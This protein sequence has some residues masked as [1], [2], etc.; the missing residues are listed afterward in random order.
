[1]RIFWLAGLAGTGKTSIAVTLCRM[2]QNDGQ[3]VFGGAFFCSRTANAAELTDAR[4]IIPTLATALA[5]RFPSFASALA[6]ELDSDAHAALKPINAQ[7][8]TLLR[9]PL[10]GISSVTS[11]IVFVVDALDECRDEN[12]VK[13]VLRA[14]SSLNCDTVVKFIFTS[15]PETHISTS[16]ISSSDRNSII[17]LHMIDKE[18]VTEDIHRY[19]ADAFTKSPLTKPWYSEADMRTLSVLSD[20]LFIFAS[21]MIVYILKA[22]SVK[23]R[24]TRLRTAL[25][26]VQNSKVVRGPLD[27]MYDLVLTRASDTAEIEPKELE[28]TLK[29]L[30]SIL[31]ARVPL[32]VG[33]LAD[34][35]GLEV[36]ELQESLQ[37]VHALV[38]VPE[39][40]DQPGLRT[41]HASFGDYLLAQNHISTSLGNETL[42]GGTLRF[43]SQRLHFNVSES[44]SSYAPNSAF[45]HGNITLAIEYACMQWI[46]HIADLVAPHNFDEK[47]D[48]LFCPQFLFWLEVM[49]VLG[50]VSRAAAMLQLAASTVRFSYQLEGDI[51]LMVLSQVR[52]A[53]LSHFFRD[54]H[55][56]VASS[57]EAIE[58]GAAHIYLSALPFSAKDS[59]VYRRFMGLFRGL[60]SIETFGID[61]HGGQIITTLTGHTGS[62]NSVAY[63]P[64]G[65]V[66]ASGSE[67]STVRIWDTRSC[68]QMG[69]PLS[70][71]DSAVKSVAFAPN[72]KNIAAGTS[73]GNIYIWDISAAQVI[74]RWL[75]GH[76]A[77]VTSVAF[78]SNGALLASTAR[79]NT[80]RLWRAHTGV[81]VFVMEGH[82]EDV[83]AVAFSPASDVLASASNDRTIRLWQSATGR[84]V[85][86]PLRGHEYMIT[87]VCFS[88]DGTMLASGSYDHDIRLWE[89]RGGESIKTL[90]GHTNWVRSIQFSPDGKVL[91]SAANDLSIILWTLKDE[92]G[93]PSSIALKGHSDSVC[94]IAFSPDGLYIASASGDRTIRIWHAGSG[95]NAV[96]SLPAHDHDVNTVAVSADGDCIVSGS[97]DSSVRIWSV[98]TAEPKLPPLLGHTNS[99]CSVA[100]STDGRFVASASKDCTVRLWDAL[101]GA[102]MGEALHGHKDEVR[103]VAFSSNSRWLVSGSYD[104]TVCIWDV[105]T[106]QPSSLGPLR[107]D[108]SVL[109]VAFSPAHQL[110]AAGDANGDVNIWNKKNGRS[111]QPPLHAKGSIYSIA[112]SP[113]GEYLASGDDVGVGIVWDI[114]TGQQALSLQGHNGSVSSIAFSPNGQLIGTGSDDYT[115]RLWDG[116]TGAQLTILHGHSYPVA[117]VVFTS[118]MSSIVSGSWDSTIRVW[119]VKA[120]LWQSTDHGDDPTAVLEHVGLQK[121]W[122]VS[123]SG[124][125]LLWIPSEY[126]AF[127]NLPTCTTLMAKHKVVVTV[128]GTWHRGDNWTA[129]WHEYSS[130]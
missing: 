130:A 58:R 114:G 37:W 121:G 48:K 105:V 33:A 65:L 118:D 7:I 75:H 20:G 29:V 64:D 43:M 93:Q 67:D 31:A 104:K 61:R 17:R 2:L 24:E 19:I 54:A 69:S 113:S 40:V 55:V 101:T 49:S 103:A 63:S 10:A 129:C 45:K 5:I 82:D 26:A 38:H 116:A 70:S 76:S 89:A 52:F 36:D 23:G 57:R 18:E 99:V 92:L 78:S 46:Y 127:L 79:D 50:R 97:D 122:I 41:L 47:I 85:G 111:A 71:D 106:R 98:Q 42:A 86:Q 34:I 16:P 124:E 74:P 28:L 117:S 96:Q 90:H 123:N 14:I 94:S 126:R 112:F 8:D 102:T 107:C 73:A 21:T 39:N 13:K 110:V 27:A 1:M 11:P 25:S 59:L 15:R 53:E 120:A 128:E 81:Q 56:F 4:N 108:S 68:E 9:Q 95:H 115:I 22:Q 119:N 3:V 35:L 109:A 88:P 12:E 62:V 125:L 66:L 80:V 87:C 6:A 51:T 83:Q 100:I 44:R 60:I 91:A 72:G 32:S 30:A 77:W 84:P